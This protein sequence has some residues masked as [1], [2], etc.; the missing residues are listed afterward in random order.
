LPPHSFALILCRGVRRTLLLL[1]LLLVGCATT[2]P[3]LE[4]DIDCILAASK[5][6][7]IAVALRVFEAVWRGELPLDQPVPVR[8]DFVSIFDGSHYALDPKEDSDP[9]L[10][11][12]VGRDLPLED[13][14]RRMIARSSNLATNNVIELIDAKRIMTIMKQIG[15]NDIEVRRGVEDDKAYEAGMNN[16]TTAYDLSLIFRALARD[17]SS[18]MLDI[19]AAQEFNNGIPKGLPRERASRTRAARSHRSHMTAA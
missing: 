10:Y 18:R 3:D 5:A 15:A 16:T 17:P 12:L 1:L 9:E 2:A 11:K 7:K 19:L 8:N 6:Q 14:V 4:R 13:L